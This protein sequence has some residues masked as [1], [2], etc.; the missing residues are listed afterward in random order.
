[1]YSPGPFT[2]AATRSLFTGRDCLDDYS[3]FFKYSASPTNHYKIFKENGYETLGIFYLY[4]ITG[5][6]V[7]D[8][9]DQI[10]YA[11]GFVFT[12]EW[13]GQYSYYE[14]K[15]KNHT[16]TDIDIMLLSNRLKL[17]LDVWIKFYEDIVSDKDCRYMIEKC[18]G[19]F[20]V[21][22]AI[23]VLKK[24]YESFLF[25]NEEYLYDFLIKGKCHILASLYGIDV[26]GYIDR[27]YLRNSV[28]LKHGADF[29][30]FA[31]HNARANWWKNRPKARQVFYALKQY[32]KNRKLDG[33]S[34]NVP[35]LCNPNSLLAFKDLP[36]CCYT[37]RNLNEFNTC[38]K[39]II[40][41]PQLALE[42][43]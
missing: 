8:Y 34:Y 37:Y 41:K 30:F 33:F 26:E 13:F 43:S 9:I 40:D 19:A 24:E 35:I 2:D 16:L 21:N 22:S 27:D 29:K 23:K 38:I 5:K 18:I 28:Y 20:D 17:T 12:S 42:K 31:K 36:D 32:A 11:S 1:M 39:D 6:N 25:N 7:T 14:E 4:Y 15:A 10:Y 3:F